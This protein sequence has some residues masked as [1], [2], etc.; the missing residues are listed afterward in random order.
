MGCPG[1]V[2]KLNLC[3]QI[4]D[5][6]LV[7]F[8]QPILNISVQSLII[9]EPGATFVVSTTYNCMIVRS[10]KFFINEKKSKNETLKLTMNEGF[11]IT[12]V[13]FT[14]ITTYRYLTVRSRKFFINGKFSKNKKLKLT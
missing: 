4:Q 8:S 11:N 2:K 1:N 3:I 7:F 9:L 12:P 14:V 13:F 10:W 6:L 5:F